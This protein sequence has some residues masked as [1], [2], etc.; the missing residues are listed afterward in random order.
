MSPTHPAPGTAEAAAEVARHVDGNAILGM[1]TD[2][3]AVDASLIELTCRACGANG[4]LGATDVEDDR[5]AAIVRCR[6][7][8]HTLLTV[9]RAESGGVQLAIGAVALLVAPAPP[10]ES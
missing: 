7:C 1:L 8:T 5:V 10:S 9:S 3:F 2:V 6:S 4:P